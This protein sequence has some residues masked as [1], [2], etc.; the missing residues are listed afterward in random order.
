MGFRVAITFNLIH[1]SMLDEG[2]LDA[3]AEFDTKETI[4]DLKSSL[5]SKGH[6]VILIEANEDA[7]EQ[8]KKHRNDIDI[9]FNI[10]E[11]L[12]GE[13]RES[14]IPA[15]L[16][17]LRIP[18]I[19]SGPLTLAICLDKPRTKQILNFYN[20]PTPKFQVFYSPDDDLSPNLNFPLIAKLSREGSAM[21]LSQ[22][23]VVKT[24]RLLK[25]G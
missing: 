11:G 23:S 10:A 17:M 5:E 22:D 12:H 8:L 16:E 25:I 9:V 4:Q 21:G 24:K 18:Y 6:S 1:E 13:S 15:F 7:Y 2:P 3:I 14:Q 19:G 20:I